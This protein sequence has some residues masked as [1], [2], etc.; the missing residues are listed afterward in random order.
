MVINVIHYNT[1]RIDRTV[2]THVIMEAPER[3]SSHFVPDLFYNV[4]KR[5]NVTELHTTA[6][7][8]QSFIALNTLP[9]N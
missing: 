4:S 1:A 2:C 6:D 7:N 3:V 9:R 8:K 5:G